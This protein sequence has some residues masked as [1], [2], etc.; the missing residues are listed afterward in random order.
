MLKLKY[1][2][3]D[4]KQAEQA[5]GLYDYDK[6]YLQYFRIS[7]NAIY[8]FE[9]AGQTCYLRLTPESE[10]EMVHLEEEL[11]LLD[12]LHQHSFTSVRTMQSK[13]GAVLSSIESNGE[14]FFVS[15][16]Y[17]VPG[18]RID[19]LV[20]EDS[21]AYKMGR[22]LAELHKLTFSCDL[23]IREHASVMTWLH[24]EFVRM[25]AEDAAS[26]L[27]LMERDR[28][29]KKAPYGI[30][31]YD[32][33][34]DN[35][36]IDGSELYIIDFNDAM[37][38]YPEMDIVNALAEID[39]AFHPAFKSGYTE[40]SDIR[41]SE[42]RM[43]FC[44]DFDLLYTKCRLMRAVEDSIDNEAEWMTKLRE[45]LIGRIESLQY[46]RPSS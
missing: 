4:F 44:R 38:H 39:E 29:F 45:K 14:K 31:H 30:V 37:Y 33:E 41:L 21:L 7:S 43:T 28:V 19:Q 8:P 15:A 22:K 35:L 17:G 36:F 9:W 13:T 1:L 10:C 32:F 40:N 20:L 5:L 11:K 42:D 16:F 2:I 12:Y 26:V 3:E 24:D 25:N 6:K 46:K 34:P 27:D 23:H 18:K